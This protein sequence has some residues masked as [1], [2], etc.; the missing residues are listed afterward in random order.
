MIGDLRQSMKLRLEEPFSVS[1]LK[2]LLAEKYCVKETDFYLTNNGR[3]VNGDD[4]LKDGDELRV[5][6]YASYVYV[7]LRF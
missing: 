6:G 1:S 7:L 2:N 3:C 5:R 4:P